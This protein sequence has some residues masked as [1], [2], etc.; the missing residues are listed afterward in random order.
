MPPLFREWQETKSDVS[1]FPENKD[2]DEVGGL[3]FQGHPSHHL[4]K[5]YVR[6]QPK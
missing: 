1:P 6:M 5:V 3:E 2:T 4:K